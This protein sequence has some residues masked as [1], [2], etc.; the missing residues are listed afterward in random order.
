MH[1]LVEEGI[2]PGI[3][4][5]DGQKAV[6]WCAISPRDSYPALERSRILKKVDEEEVWSVSCLFIEK[7]YR[8]KGVSRELLKAAIKEMKKQGGKILEG[9]P[10]EP[11]KDKMPDVFAWTGISSAYL[12]TGFRE[13]VRRS[14]TRPVMRFYIDE[15]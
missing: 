15:V 6:G 12:K 10:V 11:K 1:G 3:L 4:A 5:F 9:Y 13:V 8:Q 14:D 2:I 7:S